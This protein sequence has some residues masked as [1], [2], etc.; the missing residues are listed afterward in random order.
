MLLHIAWSSRRVDR[1]TKSMRL[2]TKSVACRL[3]LTCEI[4]KNQKPH[5]SGCVDGYGTFQ[6]A[7]GQHEMRCSGRFGIMIPPRCLCFFLSYLF[8]YQE[9]N[10]S[11][12]D[13]G[14]ELSLQ[15]GPSCAREM[16][17]LGREMCC[18]PPLC[19]QVIFLK[20]PLGR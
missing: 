6:E 8:R 2:E 9:P 19:D 16:V 10:V 11:Q 15:D 7:G 13:K 12:L 20:P 3:T 14:T 5:G 17:L 18:R 1:K 4:N